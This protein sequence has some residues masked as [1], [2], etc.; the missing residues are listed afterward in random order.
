MKKVFNFDKKRSEKKTNL[1][2]FQFYVTRAD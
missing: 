1:K 2:N